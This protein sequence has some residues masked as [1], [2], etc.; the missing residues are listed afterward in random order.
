MK[1][2]MKLAE[3]SYVINPSLLRPSFPSTVVVAIM[4]KSA[5]FKV[6]FC[7]EHMFG[8]KATSLRDK[9]TLLRDEQTLLSGKAT[10]TSDKEALL[11]RRNTNEHRPLNRK[12]TYRCH[13]IRAN[14]CDFHVPKRSADR[15]NRRRRHHGHDRQ[16]KL[17]QL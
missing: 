16:Q 7:D 13:K 2:K 9:Q 3:R 4:I 10:F 1:G 6:W 14:S 8:V 5:S 11:R 12:R 17:S 15:G